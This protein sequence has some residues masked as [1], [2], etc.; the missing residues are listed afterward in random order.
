MY[1]DSWCALSWFQL[2]RSQLSLQWAYTVS[3]NSQF[4]SKLMNHEFAY[5]KSLIIRCQTNRRI[6]RPRWLARAVISLALCSSIS[7]QLFCK[8]TL[9]AIKTWQC[10]FELTVTLWPILTDFFYNFYIV[11]SAM[12]VAFNHS[13]HAHITYFVK[14][15][16]RRFISFIKI[17][18]NK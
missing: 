5:Y 14:L 2:P 7:A 13:K 6:L 9:W 4:S 3:Y 10:I 8:Y 1:A 15:F 11:L 17:V 16:R 18:S 12:N